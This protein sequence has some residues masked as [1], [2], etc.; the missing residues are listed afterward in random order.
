[1][2]DFIKKSELWTALDAGLL[3][4]IQGK[5][6]FH[7][8][9]IQDLWLYSVI[10]AEQGQKIAE[11]GGGESRILP[12]LA[13]NNDCYNIE[14]FEG[15]NH[16]P[17]SESHIAGIKNIKT[18]VGEFSPELEENSFDILFSVSVVEHVLD[19]KFADFFNDCIRI[20]K[21]GCYMVHAIDMYIA[22]DPILFW[23]NRYEMYKNAVTDNPLVEPLGPIRQGPLAFSCDIA[24]NPDNIMYGWKT[25]SPNLD[26][27]RQ[28]AQ[29]VSLKLGAR[30]R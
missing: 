2:I 17:Q 5:F 21:P 11:I 9:T 30:K 14:K 6:S 16:G 29:S 20:L 22:D 1:M 28:D 4:Q 25:L 3:E 13:L 12:R 10:R 26:Q 27:L 8:K 15:A 7:L 24:T 18:F 19:D 23:C